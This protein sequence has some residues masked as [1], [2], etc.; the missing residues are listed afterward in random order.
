ML[1]GKKLELYSSMYPS[2]G[3]MFENEQVT[4]PDFCKF[5]S[6][7]GY[8]YGDSSI[9]V[10]GKKHTLEKGQYFGL[11]V[12]ES[13][14]VDAVDKLFLVVRLGYL[15]PDTI[16]WVESKGRLTYINGC[17]DSLLV[18][19]ARLGDASL[20]LLYFPPGIEQSFHTH[21]SIRLGCVID[22]N[23]VSCHGDTVDMQE[24]NL[25]TGTSF[26]LTEQ[27]RHRFRTENN[28][29][30]VIAFHP[31]GDWGPTDHNHTMLNRTY[32]DK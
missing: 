24:E 17:S 10:D 32:L 15:V 1:I 31:D 18:Y 3:Y 8:S 6:V 29:M 22:G 19:P 30:T 12:K 5:C 16:G 21:P 9:T 14:N 7:Y 4:L 20:N 11:S 26:C 2:A 23:G 27:E 25:N 28:S 13:V